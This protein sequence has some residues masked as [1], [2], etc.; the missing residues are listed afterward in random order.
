M[1]M[2]LGSSATSPAAATASWG[3]PGASR[4][5][6]YATSASPRAASPADS[7]RAPRKP[8]LAWPLSM[9]ARSGTAARA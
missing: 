2:K 7:S 1:L 9:P 3:R 5:A 4:R 6:T 8:I